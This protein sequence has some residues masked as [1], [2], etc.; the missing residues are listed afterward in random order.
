M[1][2]YRL[3]FQRRSGGHAIVEWIASHFNESGVL[4][5]SLRPTITWNLSPTKYW[6]ITYPIG[7][8]ENE[9]ELKKYEKGWLR[10][11]HHFLITTYEDPLRYYN[12]LYNGKISDINPTKT[13]PI[14]VV[15]DIYNNA[16][17]RLKFDTRRKKQA[18]PGWYRENILHWE[19]LISNKKFLQ[20]NYNNWLQKKTYRMRIGKK[21]GLPNNDGHLNR[22]IH[23]FG[24]GSSFTGTREKANNQM[25]INR[26]ETYIKEFGITQQF[27]FLL[28]NDHIRKLNLS[29]FGWALNKKGELIK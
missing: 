19:K 4:L 12:S 10:I 16:A 13:I 18:P 11:K 27:Q 29:K 28:N 9:K 25:L 2:E 1:I 23:S 6:N 5:N 26:W 24:G 21:L 14:I 7:N 22:T 8:V 17:S 3:F 15:R 20:L